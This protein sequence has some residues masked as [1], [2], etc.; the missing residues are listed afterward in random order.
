MPLGPPSRSPSVSYRPTNQEPCH[1]LGRGSASL[2][3]K[4]APWCIRISFCVINFRLFGSLA[5]PRFPILY[6]V[7][8]FSLT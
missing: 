4:H 3:A 7:L 6:A 8:R 2:L 5:L 1:T